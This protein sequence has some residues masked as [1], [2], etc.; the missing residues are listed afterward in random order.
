[1]PPRLSPAPRVGAFYPT[2]DPQ[3]YRDLL[4]FE[5][6]LKSNASSLNRRKRRYQ[7][8][9]AQLLC[10]IAF[11]LSEVLLQTNFL[12]VPYVRALRWILPD[13]YG[14]NAE[15]QVHRF[16]KLGLLCV[17][18]TTL[19]LFFLSGMYSEKIAY[20][21]KYVPH[22]NRALRNLNMYLNV[23]QPPLRSKL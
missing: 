23:R 10:I 7:L 11:L 8:F 16:L 14:P 4:L 20:A 5:E 12:S 18:V 2:S 21:N 1:M 9:L 19:A 13:I 3:T 17:A 6:R 22:A 15:V